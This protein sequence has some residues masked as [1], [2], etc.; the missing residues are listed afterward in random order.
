M[1][2]FSQILDVLQKLI[3]LLFLVAIWWMRRAKVPEDR[4]RALLNA[5]NLA[6][7]FVGD[8]DREV[9]ALKN[10]T[11]GAWDADAA[12]RLQQQVL[13]RLGSAVAPDLPALMAHAPKGWT[14]EQ[15]L[16]SI[17][18]SAV[19]ALKSRQTAI[20]GAPP[21]ESKTPVANDPPGPGQGSPATPT[22]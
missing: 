2:T 18:E 13:A 1:Q 20:V 12:D 17:L 15:F 5:M 3:P 4:Q 14:E 22:S 8:A 9:R 10:P 6:H 21:A 7:V 16:R 19:S 11:T